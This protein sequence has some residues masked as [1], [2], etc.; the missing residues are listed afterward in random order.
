MKYLLFAALLLGSAVFA[1]TSQLALHF[2]TGA[3]RS[4]CVQNRRAFWQLVHYW[5]S[6]PHSCGVDGL[7]HQL[8]LWI[9][10][11]APH[12]LPQIAN[13]NGFLKR[14]KTWLEAL[15][16]GGGWRAVRAKWNASDGAKNDCIRREWVGKLESLTLQILA[17]VTS[18]AHVGSFETVGTR[19][20]NSDIDTAFLPDKTLTLEERIV[21]KQIFD[22]LF[23]HFCQ[24]TPSYLMDTECFVQQVGQS[25]DTEAYLITPSGR[26]LFAQ[27][28]IQASFIKLRQSLSERDEEWL[29]IYKMILQKIQQRC[30]KKLAAMQAMLDGVQRLHCAMQLRRKSLVRSSERLKRLSNLNFSNSAL[31][32]IYLKR[33]GPYQLRIEQTGAKLARSKS[34]EPRNELSRCDSLRVQQ[35]LFGSLAESCTKE[36]YVSQGAFRVAVINRG[37]QRENSARQQDMLR[38]I[39]IPE[40][41]TIQ[42]GK[43]AVVRYELSTC[44]DHFASSLENYFQLHAHF[45]KT[46]EQD[47]QT[48][49]KI[50]LQNSKYAKRSLRDG[51]FTCERLLN[52]PHLSPLEKGRLRGNLTK[53][54]EQ[55]AV[56]KELEQIKRRVQIPRRTF[57]A[58]LFPLLCQLESTAKAAI[59]LAR[60]PS[61]DT[62]GIFAAESTFVLHQKVLREISKEVHLKR[63]W[64]TTAL[65]NRANEPLLREMPLLA[66]ISEEGG[67][68]AAQLQEANLLSLAFAGI[69]WKFFCLADA[70]IAHSQKADPLDLGDYDTRSAQFQELLFEQIA[71]LIYKLCE[72]DSA[73]ALAECRDQIRD[74]HLNLLVDWIAQFELCIDHHAQIQLDPAKAWIDL[75]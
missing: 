12:L 72:L 66:N 71:K 42:S 52:N 75:F 49:Q 20:Y 2:Q 31:Q 18:K 14:N 3:L 17:A 24:D 67:W 37:G 47:I 69:P 45:G 19:G 59:H 29:A 74:F 27:E 38:S 40:F 22:G 73:R 25:L 4:S 26:A 61:Q 33:I 48:Q 28:Q 1:D 46:T 51:I 44:L 68:S 43:R 36:G 7:G 8:I 55:L 16:E 39:N 41:H 54:L 63:I 60:I 21:A 15:I 53:G 65:P 13:I 34:L 56:F 10:R 9:D 62:L 5:A 11:S 70:N 6:H 64:V 30:P 58:S 23:C 57:T 50:L 32:L 35:A